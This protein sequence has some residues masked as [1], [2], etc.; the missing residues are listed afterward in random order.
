MTR[1][2]S[3]E[4]AEIESRIQMALAD[5]SNGRCT[6]LRKA[7]TT[8]DIRKTTLT[9]CFNGRQ[10]RIQSHENQQL[11]STHEES[12]LVRWITLATKAGYPVQH[13]ILR[14]MAQEI[15]QQCVRQINDD[16]ELVSYPPIGG[17]WTKQ[18]L[19]RHPELETVQGQSIDAAR[20]TCAT[21]KA[22]NAW[23]DAYL[24]MVQ[25]YEI[26][27]ENHYNMD[28]SGFSISKIRATRVIVNTKVRQRLQ[29]Q[30]GRQ[31][32]VSAI[33]CICVDRT[34]IPVE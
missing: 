24:D 30:P 18:F 10:T 8:Y 3:H 29:A 4:A 14:S 16:C 5:L 23:Y 13:A 12:E 1:R 20:V 2:K 9:A 25:Q 15:V 28:E 31:E 6:S 19:S 27:P 21:P 22:I 17:D 11:L 34:A 26:S 33:E 7:A 32:W